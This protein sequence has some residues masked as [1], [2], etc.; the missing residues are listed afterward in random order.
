MRKLLFQSALI[1][2]VGL[3]VLTG[4][5]PGVFP[6]LD[7]LARQYVELPQ[8]RGLST[9]VLYH[10]KTYYAGYGQLSK[11]NPAVP[12]EQTVFELGALSGVFTAAIHAVQEAQGQF[13]PGTTIN[14]VLPA[15]FQAPVFIPERFIQVTATPDSTNPAPVKEIICVPDPIAGPEAITLCQLAYHS[16]GITFPEKNFYSWHPLA[17]DAPD[18]SPEDI[19]DPE[20]FFRMTEQ[21]KFTH[22]PGEKYAF[23]NMGI[24]LLGHLLAS[25]QQTTYEQLLRSVLT[26]PLN[27]PDTRV[28]L[29]PPQRARL[30][31]GHNA[32]GR[33]AAYWDFEG[34][35][36]AAGIKSTA[37]DLMQFIQA[38][39]HQTPGIPDKAARQIRQGV[40]GVHF[41]GWKRP[42]SSAYGW[43]VSTDEGNRSIVW[44][45]GGTEGFRA[46]AAFDPQRQTAVVLLSN[47]GRDLT[48]L[49]FAMLQAL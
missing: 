3:P 8:N 44:M 21:C 39:L 25:R 34:M 22:A 48:E 1:C 28:T 11:N 14:Q 30:A 17:L 37:R 35:A 19:P 15:G 12:N 10:G 26:G 7:A 38:L 42:T 33:P 18:R 9:A 6:K 2:C 13:S 36:P 4:A 45:S 32:K 43:L 47:S 49:G 5:Q 40:I 41:P 16:S 46:F 20:T 23:S 27:L 31:P 24:A 29:L